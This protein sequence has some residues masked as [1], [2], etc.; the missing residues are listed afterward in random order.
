MKTATL[1]EIDENL[2][3]M[4]ALVEASEDGELAEGLLY[5][6]DKLE[7]DRMSKVEAICKMIQMAVTRQ[8]G[9]KAER[10]RLDMAIRQEANREEWFKEYLKASC[11]ANGMRPGADQPPYQTPLFK[12]K[13]Q[14]NSQPSVRCP[15]DVD[16]TTLPEEFTHVKVEISKSAIA[17]A[18][19]AGR[20]IPE[21][22]EVEKGFHVRIR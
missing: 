21:G 1:Y 17:A 4:M 11:Y 16:P 14:D 10:D 8:V 13:L 19:K 2:H 6:I 7:M 22:F 9:L 15:E 18:F 3:A 12:V 20:P 5:A